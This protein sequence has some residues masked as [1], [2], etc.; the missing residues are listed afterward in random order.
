MYVKEKEGLSGHV[1]D[2]AEADRADLAIEKD[3]LL[4]NGGV[5]DGCGEAL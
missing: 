4:C 2:A 3:T 1:R 5:K